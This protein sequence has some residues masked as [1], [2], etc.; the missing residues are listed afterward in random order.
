MY[1]HRMRRLFV[2]GEVLACAKS[3]KNFICLV[4]VS[5]DGWFVCKK[6]FVVIDTEDLETQFYQYLDSD[7]FQKEIMEQRRRYCESVRI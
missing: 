6:S 2:Q 1:K 3:D 4:T 5:N 7:D